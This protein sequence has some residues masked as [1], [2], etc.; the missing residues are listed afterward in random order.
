MCYVKRNARCRIEP[1]IRAPFRISW[2]HAVANSV[3][4]P[5]RPIAS[6]TSLAIEKKRAPLPYLDLLSHIRNTLFE[7]LLVPHQLKRIDKRQQ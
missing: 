3:S 4:V 7:V 5:D 1:R 2:V 6:R